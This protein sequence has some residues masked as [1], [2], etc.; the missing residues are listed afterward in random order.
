MI[1][2]ELHCPFRGTVEADERQRRNPKTARNAE[3]VSAPLFP[4][5]RKGSQQ[6]P[7]HAEVVRIEQ[8]AD[9]FVARLLCGREQARAGIIYKNIQPAEMLK[10]LLNDLGHLLPIGLPRGPLAGPRLRVL[11][12][13]NDLPAFARWP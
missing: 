2:A 12:K 4:H 6:H 8:F 13:V 9:L 5:R 3:N 7:N 1:R 11:F 10:R